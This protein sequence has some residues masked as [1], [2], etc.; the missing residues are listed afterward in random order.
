MP[1]QSAISGSQAE[2]NPDSSLSWAQTI[3]VWQ[4]VRL[5]LCCTT[6]PEQGNQTWLLE[7]LVYALQRSAPSVL[8]HRSPDQC[9]F[10]QRTRVDFFSSL[11]ICA[12]DS[13]I[14]HTSHWQSTCNQ[15]RGMDTRLPRAAGTSMVQR[16]YHPGS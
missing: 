2:C 8:C 16:C 10:T 6:Q 12:T 5:G 3:C 15:K 7:H 11:L 13:V 9:F 4:L 14:K 1:L